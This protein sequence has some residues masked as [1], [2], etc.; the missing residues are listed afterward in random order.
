MKMEQAEIATYL[1][2]ISLFAHL[3]QSERLSLAEKAHQT[4]KKAKQ[5]LVRDGDTLSHLYILREG[6]G[7]C[8]FLHPDGKKTVTYHIEPD[9]PL[10][11]EAALM[12]TRHNGTIEIVEDATVLALP[13]DRITRLMDTDAAF[14]TQVA[15]YAMDS[16]LRLTDLLKDLS[17]E[18]PARLGRYLF[19]RALESG[20]PHED[21][22]YFDLGLK[23]GVLADFLGI[24]PE[25]LSRLLS[26]LQNDKVIT[27][28]GPKIIVNNIKNLVQL[29]EGVS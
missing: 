26:Q 17:F 3:D 2:G 29:S 1:Q 13:I 12:G 21:G 22:V 7:L 16:V 5:V 18:A 24:T 11:V 28:N 23:K 25:T 9:K 14:A 19:R 20:E 27:V 6:K 15:R 8:Y 10:A 4:A